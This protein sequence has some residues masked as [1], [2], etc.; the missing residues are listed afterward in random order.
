MDPVTQG[1]L[2]GIVAQGFAKRAQLRLAAGC[3]ILG[4]LAADLDIF[5]KSDTDPLLRLEFHRHFTHALA[6]IPIG[7][8]IVA[9]AI[10]FLLRLLKRP[11]DFKPV[12]CFATLGY[13]THGLLDTC[14]SYGTYL[15]WPFSNAR[16]SWDIMSIIDPMF[17]VPLLILLAIATFRKSLTTVY[18]GLTIGAL[19]FSFAAYQHHVAVQTLTQFAKSQEHP[20]SRFRVMPT[21]GNL[22]LWRGL[23]ESAGRYHVAAIFVNPMETPSVQ[24]GDSLPAL[25]VETELGHLPAQQQKDAL[26]FNHFADGFLAHLSDDPNVLIDMRYA[27]LPNSVK[28]LW[29]VRFSP[30]N[31]D[32][33]QHVERIRFSTSR[34]E[35]LDQL[36][37]MLGGEKAKEGPP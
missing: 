23:Y 8:L 2:G 25:D 17:T 28:P 12:Y 32:P 20:I 6:F 33:D 29:G 34:K 13:A 11:P 35:R 7:G 36:W 1:V 22:I 14:T 18:A 30:Q 19:Y 24:Y 4:G 10:Y 9:A 21:L 16:L 31:P 26:R 27:A 3:G 5:I 15:L 37:L